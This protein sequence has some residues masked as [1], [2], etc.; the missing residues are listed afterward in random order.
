MGT[1]CDYRNDYY[2]EGLRTVTKEK[3]TVERRRI[4]IQE[5]YEKV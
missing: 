1:H 2:V 3:Q 4:V 5:N